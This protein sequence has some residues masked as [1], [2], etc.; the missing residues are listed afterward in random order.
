M[1]SDAVDH[2]DHAIDLLAVLGQLLNHLGG[3]LHAIGE[4]GNGGLYAADHLLPAAGQVVGG[5]RQITGSPGVLSDVMDR[6]SHL[7]DGRGGLVRLA[8]LT[9][10]AVL[11]FVHAA[12]QARGSGIQLR[13]GVCHGVD[14]SLI[15]G[16]HGIER[17]GHLADLIGAGQRH[18]GRQITGFFDMQHHILEGVELAEQ[19]T[20]QQLRGA[21][22]GQHQHQDG[23]CIIGQ[24]LDEHLR[25]A[26][27]VGQYGD[28][29]TILAADHLGSGQ[30]VLPEQWHV[31]ERYPAV[32]VAQL[33]QRLTVD[34]RQAV[35]HQWQQV[36]GFGQ[37]LIGRPH[38]EQVRLSLGIGV[39]GVAA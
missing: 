7:I 34:G 19:K 38:A 4:V 21:E 14:H 16:L 28:L 11:H 3:F 18:A 6:G 37:W 5:L 36:L 17:A 15:T 27:R 20:D 33:R 8:L 24:T 2:T 1:F 25:Q 29:L 12:G 32:G 26:G 9:E 23:R 31:I 22:H 13:G 35:G 39:G 10:H 30:R